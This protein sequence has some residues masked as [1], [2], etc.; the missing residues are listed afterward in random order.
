MSLALTVL[1]YALV[2]ASAVMLAWFVYRPSENFDQRAKRFRDGA[3]LAVT[4]LIF[5]V[6]ADAAVASGAALLLVVGHLLQ[7]ECDIENGF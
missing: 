1:A 2:A 7:H 4:A 6:P 3:G 5:G